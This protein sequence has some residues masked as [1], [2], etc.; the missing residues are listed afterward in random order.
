MRM[1]ASCPY[2]QDETAGQRVTGTAVI[3]DMR[4]PP[5]GG[6]PTHTPLQKRSS[7]PADTSAES[8]AGVALWTMKPAPGSGVSVGS[9][10][11]SCAN[12]RAVTRPRIRPRTN[13]LRRWRPP[14]PR[15]GSVR[16]G[17]C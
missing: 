1:A 12:L 3:F 4:V 5:L 13:A 2:S 7:A 15:A 11:R 10:T 6:Q 8:V 17:G 9:L 14:P 16:T